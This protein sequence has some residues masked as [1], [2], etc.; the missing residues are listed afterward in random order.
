[1]MGWLIDR[2]LGP[3]ATAGRIAPEPDALAAHLGPTRCPWRTPAA[4][5]FLDAA[6]LAVGTRPR[7]A[8]LRV[9]PQQRG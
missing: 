2:L 6:P 1:M 4:P 7:R 3:A 8:P 5:R 9:P